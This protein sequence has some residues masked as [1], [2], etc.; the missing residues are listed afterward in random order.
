MEKKFSF[1]QGCEKIQPIFYPRFYRALPS[2]FAHRIASEPQRAGSLPAWKTSV[3]PFP[4]FHG[5]RII[6]SR[7]SGIKMVK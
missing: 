2:L 4:H 1:I 5:R 6:D 3:F 7:N